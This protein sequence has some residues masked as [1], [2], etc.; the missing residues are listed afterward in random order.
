M[1]RSPASVTGSP[2]TIS[3]APYSC[4]IDAMRARSLRRSRHSIVVTGNAKVPPGSETATPI[5]LLP[6]SSARIT[7]R[8][9]PDARWLWDAARDG[10][11]RVLLLLYLLPGSPQRRPLCYLL[12]WPNAGDS[13]DPPRRV[14]EDR[15]NAHGTVRR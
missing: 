3:R 9:R 1:P 4:A 2:T 11:R 10:A 13:R 7:R 14:A 5:R 8:V 6:T 12:R 15:A